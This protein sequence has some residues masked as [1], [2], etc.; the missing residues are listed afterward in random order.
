[1]YHLLPAQ[2]TVLRP[3]PRNQELEAVVTTTV[4]FEKTN[5]I[6]AAEVEL[7]YS[8]VIILKPK[9]FA[10]EFAP[11]LSQIKLFRTIFLHR[12]EY[13]IRNFR[14]A[15]LIR[16]LSPS[17][18]YNIILLTFDLSFLHMPKTSLVKIH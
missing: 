17:V 1:M 10:L 14:Y 13:F 11:N 3:R 16:T 9:L 2:K 5:Q 18:R 4:S 6:A 8:S 15:L 12:F 7:T